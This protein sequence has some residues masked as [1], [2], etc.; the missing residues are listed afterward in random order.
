MKCGHWR[1]RY[2]LTSPI[3]GSGCGSLMSAS[4]SSVESH[5]SILQSKSTLLSPRSAINGAVFSIEK[6]QFIEPDSLSS[7]GP[8]R[9]LQDNDLMWNSTGLGTLGRIAIYKTAANPYELAVAD[10]YAL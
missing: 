2:R 6:A 3:R 7:Y 9:L 4:T 5:R 8:E 1:M 10:I